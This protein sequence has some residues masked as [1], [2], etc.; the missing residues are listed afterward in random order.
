LPVFERE[1][2]IWPAKVHLIRDPCSQRDLAPVIDPPSQRPT[3][4]KLS[5]KSNFQWTNWRCPNSWYPSA[6]NYLCA[7]ACYLES[8]EGFVSLVSSL[9]S[10]TA[11]KAEKVAE[12]SI[13]CLGRVI[14]AP[15]AF[16]IL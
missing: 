13:H 2:C 8:L 15:L 10:L 1:S 7:K 5:W 6:A 11:G 14:Q 9:G 3:W 4:E 12:L 16:Q